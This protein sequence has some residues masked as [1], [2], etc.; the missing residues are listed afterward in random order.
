MLQVCLKNAF[1]G[2]ISVDGKYALKGQKKV[3]PVI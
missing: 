2:D 1:F 3:S